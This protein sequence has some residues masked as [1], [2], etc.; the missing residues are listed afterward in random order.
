MLAS[1]GKVLQEEAPSSIFQMNLPVGLTT[2]DPAFAGDQPSIWMCG[3]LFSGLVELDTAL[4]VQPLIARR[5][6]ISDSGLTY[7]FH[8]RDDVFFHPDTAF[9]PARTRRVQAQDFVYS[10]TRIC[11]PATASRGL[12][13]F[14]GKVQGVDSFR[15]SSA[16][17]IAGFGAPDDTTLIIRLQK[18]FPPFLSLLAM[19]Y[20][21]V[22]PH[23]AITFYGKDFRIHP[24]GTGPFRF[25][26]WSP[27]RSLILLRNE[28]YFEHDAQGK[29]LPYLQAIRVRFMQERLSE[30]MELC[31]G[32][33]DFIN[34]VDKSTRDEIF[35]PA[36]KIRPKYLD[37]FQF[38]ISPQLNTEFIGILVD[39]TSPL[40]QNHPL[41]DKRVR[42]ALNYAIDRTQLVDYV[43]NGQGTP[44][45]S[46]IVPPG[47]PG[48]DPIA[49][50]GYTYDPDR[51]AQ[52]LAQAGYPSGKG[53]PVLSLKSTPTY[54]S[55][56]EFVQKSFERIGVTLAI[57]NLD[58]PTLREMA[59][60][61]EIHLWRA[62]WIADY[63]DPENYLGLFTTANI[64]PNGPNRTRFS[65]PAYDKLFAQGLN[66]TSD[67][68]RQ[69]LQHQMENTMLQEAPIIPLYYD[70]ILRVISKKVQGLETNPLNQLFLKRVHK[71]N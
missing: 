35:L 54:Q 21:A 48:F 38:H 11:D 12:W 41:R 7:T 33:L 37:Q 32:R 8:L 55:A 67:S 66:T 47:M 51:A 17:T 61:G 63:P 59:S 23:E 1:C 10:F 22:V 3:Q 39:T 36:G 31:Q 71:L 40:L 44:A 14:N 34:G 19:A 5:W 50:Q 70:R 42:L 57:D 15:D 24:V 4:A 16:T 43:L 49:V 68:L 30:F 26:S 28:H 53:L 60:K 18:P 9:G 65:N 52:L 29:P 56:M 69:S 45:T 25:K 58:S 64:P 20:G 46:G 27:G 13:V 62:S 2:L 6:T